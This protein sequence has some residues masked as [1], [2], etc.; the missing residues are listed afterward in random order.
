MSNVNKVIVRNQ[1]GELVSA[2]D[3]NSVTLNFPM[4]FGNDLIKE[5]NERDVTV[6][7][8]KDYNTDEIK[9]SLLN[10]DDD[11]SNRVEKAFLRFGG[12]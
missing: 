7:V 1:Q 2:E 4:W 6:I 11:L 12:L 3:K 9:F 10:G 5:I 8:K